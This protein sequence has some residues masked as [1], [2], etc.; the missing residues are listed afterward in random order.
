MTTKT[1]LITGASRGIGRAAALRF[2]Q[3]SWHVHAGVRS[4]EAARE[5]ADAAGGRVRPVVLDVASATDLAALASALPERL[6]AV[7]NNAGIVVDGPVEHLAAEA[8]RQQFE[9][10][11]VGAVQVTRA[12]LPLLRAS[13]GRVVFVSSVSGRVTTPWTG[14]Y[15]ASKYALEAVADALR[16]ELRPWRIGV[17][18]VEPTATATDLWANSTTMIDETEAAM[19]PGLRELYTSHIAGMRRSAALI[20]RFA[21][22]TDHVAA[23]IEKALTDQ[24]PRARYPVGLQARALVWSLPLVPTRLADTLVARLSGV[25]SAV[26]R[27]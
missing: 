13:S 1:V 12:A 18:L 11:V 23:A 9:V 3:N 24:R 22:S 15:C 25:P 21:V 8:L 4:P 16:I 14:A 5:L 10:N 17:S 7:V 26:G 20:Q 19:E 27:L 6:D 2:A